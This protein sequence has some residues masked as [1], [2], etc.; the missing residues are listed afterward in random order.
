MARKHIGRL[1]W[2]GVIA[3]CALFLLAPD[4]R[5]QFTAERKKC[6]I[7]GGVGVPNVTM[8]VTGVSP[9]PITD[10][11]GAYTVEVDWGWSGTIKPVQLG[12]VF[13]PAER[14]YTNVQASV[15]GENYTARLL[16]FTI[17]GT[18]GVGGVRLAGFLTEVTSDDN[19]RYSTEV[20]FGWTGIV[21]P[22]KMGYRFEPSTRQYKA[23]ADQKQENYKA[24][25]LTF[26]IS[27]NVTTAGVMMKGLPGNPVSQEGGAY[28]AQVGYGWT[29]TV[30]PTKEGYRFTPESRPYSLVVQP[31]P[32]EDYTAEVFT[33]KISGSTGMPGVVLKGLPND[34]ISDSNGYYSVDVEYGTS[35]KITPEYPGYKF[36]PPSRDFTKVVADQPNVDFAASVIFLTISGKTGVPNVTLNGLPGNVTSDSA[37]TYS[38]QVEYGWSDSVTPTK[39]GYY[40]EP[41]TKVYNAVTQNQKQ[42]YTAK[43]VTFEIS[44]RIGDLPG[45]ALVGLPGPP[46]VTGADGT[47]KAEVP[48]KWNGTITPKKAGFEFE[49]PSK[50]YKDVLM[51]MSGEDYTGRIIQYTISG[52]ITGEDGP[53][54]DITVLAD[55]TGGG[56]G[57]TDSAG[58]FQIKV[59]HAWRG[60]LVPQHEGYTYIPPNRPLEAVGQNVLR[61]DFTAKIKM[62]T[63]TDRVAA[64]EGPTAVPIADV[65]VV[66]QP[67][68][69]QARTGNDGKYTLR[70]PFGWSGQLTFDKPG[71]NLTPADP[72]AYSYTDL[73]ENVDRTVVKPP[74][75]TAKPPVVPPDTTAKPPVVPPDTTARPAVIPP[76]TTMTLAQAQQRLAQVQQDLAAQNAKFVD[77]SRQNKPVP[78]QLQQQITQLQQEQSSLQMLLMSLQTTDTTLA[79]VKPPVVPPDQTTTASPLMPTILDAL[80]MIMQR[81][82]AKIMIDATVK[83]TPVAISPEVMSATTAGMALDLLIR[84]QAVYKYRVIGENAFIVYK[85]INYLF[86]GDDLRQALQDLSTAAEVPIIPDPNVAGRVFADIR[87]Q[88]LEKA[89]EIMLAGTGYVVKQT[90]EYYLVADRSPLSPSFPEISVTKVIPL[91]YITPDRVK[92]LVSTAFDPYVKAEPADPRDP[93]NRGSLVTITAPEKLAARIEA[94]IR[95]LDN[96]PRQVLLDARVVTLE[97][98]NLL[99]LGVEWGW[100]R[101]QAGFNYD[102][103]GN[104]LTPPSNFM[105][106]FRLGYTSGREF[107][108]SLL[109][110]L[111]LLQESSQAEIV[112]SPQILAQDSRLSQ[113]KVVTEE[114]FMM[115]PPPNQSTLFTNSQLEKIESGTVLS[116]TPHIGDHNDMTLELAI[117]VSDSIPSARGSGLP[118]VTRRIAR[119]LVTVED[120]GTVALAGLTENRSRSKDTSTPGLSK[121]PLIGPLFKNQ[122]K[123]KANREI[124]VFVTAHLIHDAKDIALRTPPQMDQATVRVPA[125]G[126]DEDEF[127]QDLERA[128]ANRSNR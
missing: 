49:P 103:T 91:S 97:R 46:V 71:W 109:A 63:I 32:G 29:G 15:S 38:V 8:Q 56:Q 18:T 17:A 2:G 45:V 36:D 61:Q 47:Y 72:T 93:N 64:G 126:G 41:S 69:Y 33:Y 83:P 20:D 31:M 7:S 57:I 79:L 92:T 68:N 116:I 95:R 3:L 42:D 60:R 107:T 65:T 24:V 123:D 50:E 4:A 62:L 102:S 124:A 53:L 76:T 112:S 80:T 35:L 118:V 89:L 74:V 37:C 1:S 59:N 34:P 127:K 5:C 75:T 43:P 115:T 96:R 73:K 121:L 51:V 10:Q 81:T 26:A 86:S 55:G 48:Y 39:E 94:D 66:G 98:G 21:T 125:V 12:Y 105:A 67:G 30:T 14:P 122:N 13:Q 77:I 28:T 110:A 88:P 11:N 119:N 128:M 84:S 117:E 101:L 9:A 85:P 27:G 40:F 19:G 58:E 108:D 104:A 99:N 78:A 6:V 44:G 120:G 70:V 22:E 111:N 87:D 100:P 52:K 54:A 106:G 23:T 113:L 16:T 25:E 114:W 90:P 82:G